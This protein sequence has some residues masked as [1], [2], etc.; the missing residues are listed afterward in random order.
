MQNQEASSTSTQL[1]WG[2]TINTTEVQTKLRN[3]INTF[4][5][6]NDEDENYT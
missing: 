4:V 6:L 3:F 5:M 2:T 1:I